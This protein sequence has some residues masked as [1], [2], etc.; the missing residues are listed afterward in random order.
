MKSPVGFGILFALI[1]VI[2]KMLFFFFGWFETNIVPT[3]FINMFLLLASISV[4]LYYYM[5]YRSGAVE[6]MFKEAKQAVRAGLVYTV[7][8]AG[9][10]FVFYQYIDAAMIAKMQNDRIAAFSSGLDDPATFSQIRK[11]NEAFELMSK[12]EILAEVKS[13]VDQFVSARSVFLISLLS[14]LMLSMVYSI[15]VT[16][17]YRKVLFR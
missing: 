4:G 14:M 12:E 15:L 5:R 9:F 3:A 1:F 10:L 17:V 16:I 7:I 13:N 8:V 11:S 2:I 6:S